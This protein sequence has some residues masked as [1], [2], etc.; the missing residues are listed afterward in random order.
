[1]RF[2]RAIARKSGSREVALSALAEA[3][4]A[5]ARTPRSEFGDRERTF[6]SSRAT[7][8]AARER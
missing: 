6:A 4:R 3:I 1:M 8:D 5:R 2:L 7:I